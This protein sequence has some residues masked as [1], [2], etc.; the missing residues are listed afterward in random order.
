MTGKAFREITRPPVWLLKW[1][2]M[3]I[4]FAD[5]IWTCING[6]IDEERVMIESLTAIKRAGADMFL[7]YFAK[8]AA[9]WIDKNKK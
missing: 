7:T 2:G 9:K 4:L 1:R 5:V 6:W 3:Q 8:D